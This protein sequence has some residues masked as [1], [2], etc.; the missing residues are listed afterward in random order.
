[1]SYQHSKAW[2]A[3]ENSD[4]AK[5]VLAAAQQD[6]AKNPNPN[7]A[8]G[9]LESSSWQ[10]GTGDVPIN[11]EGA[12][13][14]SSGTPIKFHNLNET[15]TPIQELATRAPTGRV[16]KVLTRLVKIAEAWENSQEEKLQPYVAELDDIINTTMEEYKSDVQASTEGEKTEG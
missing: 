8:P 7:S 5:K 4:Y 10:A 3:F 9:N 11:P 12:G 6:S 14:G 1:M 16:A 15:A 2:E 13:G